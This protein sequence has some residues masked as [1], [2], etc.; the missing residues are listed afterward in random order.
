MK[1]PNFM[2]QWLMPDPVKVRKAYA[3]QLR[4]KLKTLET[5]QAKLTK[6]I[7]GIS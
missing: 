4:K 1:L 3:K 7:K 6:I 2:I 5:A